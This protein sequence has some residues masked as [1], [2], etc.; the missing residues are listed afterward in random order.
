M[1]IET[2]G[3]RRYRKQILLAMANIDSE[4]VTMEQLT[5]EVSGQLDDEI[6]STALSGPLRQLKTPALGNILRDV[7]KHEGGGRAFNYTA[8]SDP[9]MRAFIRMRFA[10]EVEGVFDDSPTK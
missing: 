9:S 6:P 3:T 2:T 5:K 1:A 4:Y 8:F 7:E 10:G